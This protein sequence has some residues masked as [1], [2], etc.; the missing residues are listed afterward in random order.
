VTRTVEIYRPET[1]EGQT[2]TTA[3][4]VVDANIQLI[5]D[6]ALTGD[7]TSGTPWGPA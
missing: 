2:V 6:A 4:G 3:S 5:N 7:G 1:T